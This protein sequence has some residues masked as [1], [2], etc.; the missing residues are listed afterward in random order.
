MGTVDGLSRKIFP[1]IGALVPRITTA[2]IA[3]SSIAPMKIIDY[4]SSGRPIVATDLPT[5]TQIL[6]D[7]TAVLVAVDEL[8]I[9]DGLR[10]VVADQEASQQMARRAKSKVEN[11]I[12][13][14][15]FS[16]RLLAA[17]AHAVGPGG[18]TAS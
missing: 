13:D 2:A 14:E 7:T 5:H 18:D 6:D 11:L 10:R 15:I 4:M 12:S 9:A 1:R 17:I 8:A 3:Q 16:E